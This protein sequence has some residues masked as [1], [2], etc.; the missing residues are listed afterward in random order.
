M[1]PAKVTVR[2]DLN[3]IISDFSTH[4]LHLM[5]DRQKNTSF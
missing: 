1:E 3:K 5:M 2:V 4:N